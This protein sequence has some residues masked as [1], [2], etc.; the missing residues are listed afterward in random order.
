MSNKGEFPLLT[1]LQALDVVSVLALGHSHRC[2]V[3]SYCFN[4]NSLTMYD[5]E[6]LFIC[7]FAMW[8]SPLVTYLFK[9]FAHLKIALFSFSL[10]DFKGSL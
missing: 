9:Y 10:L 2:V 3:V 4:V 6:Y 5:V 1:S 7:S 8:I